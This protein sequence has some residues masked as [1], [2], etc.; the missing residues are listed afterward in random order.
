MYSSKRI[1]FKAWILPVTR[2]AAGQPTAAK[3]TG[4]S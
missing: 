4:S 2:E 3:G 1:D